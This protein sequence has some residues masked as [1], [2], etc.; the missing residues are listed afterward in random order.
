MD[1]ACSAGKARSSRNAVMNCAQTKKG[2]RNQVSPGARSCT[3][4]VMKFIAPSSDEKISRSIPTS[5]YV[6]PAVGEMSDSG[7]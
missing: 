7:G 1:A 5:Q 6:W 2:S 4:V 3:I